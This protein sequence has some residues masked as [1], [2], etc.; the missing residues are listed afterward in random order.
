MINIGGSNKVNELRAIR[1]E[2]KNVI[3]FLRAHRKDFGEVYPLAAIRH[4]WGCLIICGMHMKTKVE[5]KKL[6][7]GIDNF[8]NWA[9]ENFVEGIERI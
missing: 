3:P 1:P 4:G 8:C 2:T 5:L 6:V 7:A 9:R